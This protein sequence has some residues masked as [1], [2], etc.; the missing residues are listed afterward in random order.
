MAL[1]LLGGTLVLV[2]SACAQITNIHN[3][4][5]TPRPAR[6]LAHYTL[7]G[8]AADRTGNSAPM[9]LWNTTFTNGTLC[10]NGLYELGDPQGFHALATISGFSYESFTVALDFFAADFANDNILTGG[11]SYRWFSLRHNAGR[12]EVTLNN[13]SLV[14]LLPDGALRTN[15]WQNVLCSVDASAKRIIT[16]LDGRRL[17]DVVLSPDFSFEVI[18]SP[19]ENSDRVFMFANYSNASVFHGY[20]DNLKVWSR[21]LNSPEIE[22]MLSAP[23]LSIEKAVVVSWPSFP[24]GFVLQ[25]ST[26][27]NG[28]YQNYPGT[29][30]TEGAESKAVVPLGS[31]QRFFQLVKP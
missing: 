8:T 23:I 27:I 5:E 3:F 28:P 17:Q 26:D 7:D 9:E 14:Y 2:E 11:P 19:V 13:Q 4:L 31:S 20:V 22:A 25:S 6:L 29:I 12:L 30:F 16:V 15:E 10:L 24:P 18:G 1:C 21:A